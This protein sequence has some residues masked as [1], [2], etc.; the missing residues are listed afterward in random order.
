M[1][2][3]VLSTNGGNSFAVQ[4]A[5]FQFKRAA[6]LDRNNKGALIN[7]LYL[8]CMTGARKDKALQ[9]T[10]AEDAVLQNELRES[11][12]TAHLVPGDR[13][14]VQSLSELLVENRLCLEDAEVQALLDAAL[15]N[16]E[17]KGLIRGMINAV[18]MDYAVAKIGS[19]PL[20]LRYARAA[21]D[22]DPGNVPPARCPSAP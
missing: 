5:R 8:D 4:T 11:F 15:A 14:L 10:P 18:A 17:A 21:V 12:A 2:R 19:L 6:E 13:G 20:G 7:L 3:T 1:E 9:K 16:P 22:S